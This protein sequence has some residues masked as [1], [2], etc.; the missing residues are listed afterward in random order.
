MVK[1]CS[2]EVVLYDHLQGLFHAKASMHNKKT[3]SGGR[4]YQVNLRE[5][6]CTCGKLLIHGFSC[7]HIFVACKSRSIDFR[8]FVQN[9]YTTHPYFNTWVPLFNPICNEYE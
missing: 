4:T 2:H 9:Y 8:S 5:H 6:G 1:A 3:S 7:S